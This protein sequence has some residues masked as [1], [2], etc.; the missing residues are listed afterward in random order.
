MY[1]KMLPLY[2]CL[3]GPL[4]FFGLVGPHIRVV[5][6][7][8]LGPN[9]PPHDLT[10]PNSFQWNCKPSPILL[11]VGTGPPLDLE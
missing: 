7:S 11:N 1:T 8:H 5:K 9:A 10:G 4:S 2:F 6:F 3:V